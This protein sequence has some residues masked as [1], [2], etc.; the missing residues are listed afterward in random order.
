MKEN[1]GINGNNTTK[2]YKIA[3]NRLH[4]TPE[5]LPFR[6]RYIKLEVIGSLVILWELLVQVTRIMPYLKIERIR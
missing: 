5:A 4:L 3:N 6:K 2:I 1:C